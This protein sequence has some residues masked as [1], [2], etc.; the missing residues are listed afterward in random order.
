MAKKFLGR[1]LPDFICIAPTKKAETVTGADGEEYVS[2]ERDKD[3]SYYEV[4][5]VGDNAHKRGLHV[6]PQMFVDVFLK[7]EKWH[8]YDG[9]QYAAVHIDDVQV[10]FDPNG[11]LVKIFDKW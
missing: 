9:V 2:S 10:V 7:P 11:V 8:E 3:E 4:L 1:P 6:Y 5:A